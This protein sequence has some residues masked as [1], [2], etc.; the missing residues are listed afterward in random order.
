MKSHD[1]ETELL[2]DMFAVVALHALLQAEDYQRIPADM[3][4]QDAYL[5]A[6]AMMQARNK[7]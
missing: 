3:T 6:D 7:K 1:A 5:Y 4:C 2:R